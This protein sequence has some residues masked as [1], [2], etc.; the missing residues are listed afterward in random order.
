M[1]DQQKIPL[2]DLK[3]K[4]IILLVELEIFKNPGDIPKKSIPIP[5]NPGILG[6]SDLGFFWD[7]NPKIPG[8]L[9]RDLG[10]RKNPIPLPPLVSMA[11][12]SNFDLCP[13]ILTTFGKN[14]PKIGL[15]LNLA[16]KL[17]NRFI[18]RQQLYITFKQRAT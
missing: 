12:F 4:T 13:E 11:L 16:P 17:K 7:K 9:S 18:A 2:I 5:K 1:S 14:V 8:F 15:I 10:S 3:Y 6:F